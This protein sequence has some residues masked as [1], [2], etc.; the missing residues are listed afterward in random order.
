MPTRAR[1][2]RRKA[3]TAVSFGTTTSE[4][5]KGLTGGNPTIADILGT[6]FLGVM[7]AACAVSGR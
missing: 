3:L 6:L 7:L 2:A 5:G 1:P 4:L